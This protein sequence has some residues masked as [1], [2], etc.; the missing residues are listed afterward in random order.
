MKRIKKEYYFIAILL[1]MFILLTFF[2]VGGKL[3]MI[4]KLVFNNVIKLENSAITKTLYVITSMA[5]TIGILVLTILT[6]IIFIRKK[7]FSDFKYVIANVSVGVILMQVLKHIIKR[8]RPSWKWIK[9]G[10]FSYPSGHTISAMLLYGTLILLI[11][12]RYHGKYKKQL[13]ALATIMI[14]LTGLSRIYFGVHY[15]TDVIASIILGTIILI[16]SSMIMNKEYGSNDKNK[17]RKTI[18]IK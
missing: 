16:I 4:D 2:V 7:R 9:Q 18:Q 11:S 6:A 1:I 10:G 3:D 13:I 8:I 17:D 15:L 12:K 5:S 14:I